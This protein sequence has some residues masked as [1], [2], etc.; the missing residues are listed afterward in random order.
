MS[1]TPKTFNEVNSLPAAKLKKLCKE[2]AIDCTYGK[3]A[4]INLLCQCLSISSTGTEN[5]APVL[6]RGKHHSLT[7]VQLADFQKL[8]PAYLV[9]LEGWTT[10]LRKVPEVDDYIVKHYLKDTVVIKEEETRYYKLCRPY[11]LKPCVHSMRLH[12]TPIPSSSTFVVIH[13]QCNPSQSA[14]PDDVKVVFA[15]L[16]SITGHPLG[17]YCTCTAGLVV[18]LL[19]F[20]FKVQCLL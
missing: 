18:L 20:H 17:G 2:H 8:T 3:K 9:S 6:P 4:K 12:L 16:D 11:Q 7:N 1:G 15:V 14:S 5:Q 19:V 10:D 13:S